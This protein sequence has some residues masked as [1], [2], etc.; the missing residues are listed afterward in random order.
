[1]IDSDATGPI[2][3]SREEFL[4]MGRSQMERIINERDNLKLKLERQVHENQVHLLNVI[5]NCKIGF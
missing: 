3:L 2:F 4:E 5:A 1:M